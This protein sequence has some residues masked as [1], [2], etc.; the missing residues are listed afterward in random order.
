[1]VAT[2]CNDPLAT[3][4]GDYKR[5]DALIAALPAS[6]WRRLSVGAGARGPREFDW[7]RILL[8]SPGA[9]TG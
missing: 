8:R 5:A 3:I 2:R 9:G 7:A 1:V 6:A 4:S